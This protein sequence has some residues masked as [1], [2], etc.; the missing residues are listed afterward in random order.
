[1]AFSGYKTV[2]LANDVFL[3]FFKSCR[4]LFFDVFPF[5]PST[6]KLLDD[7]HVIRRCATTCSVRFLVLNQA[8][9]GDK[10]DRYGAGD[11]DSAEEGDGDSE[12]DVGRRRYLKI[13]T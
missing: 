9:D 1:M 12:G 7:F 4:R 8:E 11:G 13:E 6:D 2:I 5:A 3:S 10:G